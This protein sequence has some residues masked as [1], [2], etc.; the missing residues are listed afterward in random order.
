MKNVLVLGGTGFVGAPVCEMLLRQGWQVTVP[1]RQRANAELL[2]RSFPEVRLLELDVHDEAALTR[3]LAG[4]EAVVNLVAILHGTA[5]A[6]EKVHVKLPQK[7][8]R[9][10]GA[11]GVRQVVH[12]SALGADA[13]RPQSAPSMYLR[14]KGQGEAD[15]LQAAALGQHYKF[16]LT[17]LRPS[18]I[19]GVNDKFLN[20]FAQLQKVLPVMPL[21]SA[22]TRFQPVWV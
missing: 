19:F 11:A 8:A 13:T 6:F 7:L 5:D 12:L 21:A 3:A 1:T 10:C 9:G 18:V 15:L 4:Q 16:D 22:A 17:I 14:S 2:H 20:V